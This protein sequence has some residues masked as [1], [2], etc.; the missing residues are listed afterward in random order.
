V[1]RAFVTREREV[2]DAIYRC[3]KNACFE[4]H[5]IAFIQQLMAEIDGYI[6]AHNISSKTLDVKVDL[7]LGRLASSTDGSK[8][9]FESYY[10]CAL[11]VN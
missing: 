11:S 7:N 4:V 2:I 9:S 3:C 6:S 8:S 10:K 1:V 5:R